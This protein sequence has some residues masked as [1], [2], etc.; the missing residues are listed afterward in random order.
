MVKPH[1]QGACNTTMHQQ[2]AQKVSPETG[3]IVALLPFMMFH[4]VH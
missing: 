3:W 4:D 1:D 2:Q